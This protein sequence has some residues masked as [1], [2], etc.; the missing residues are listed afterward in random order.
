MKKG[1]KRIVW[2]II[3]L[4]IIALILFLAKGPIGSFLIVQDQLKKVDVIVVLGGDN[5]RVEEA[6]RL[7]KKG[8]LRH[9]IMSGG[10]FDAQVSMA[11]VMKEQA[12]RLDV[13]QENI[14]VEAEA[15]HTFEHPVFVKPIMQARGFKSAIVVSSPY[16]MRRT[17]MLFDRTFKNSGIDLI[18]YPVQ[19]TWF[20]VDR[21]WTSAPSRRVVVMEYTKLV[22]NFFGNRFSKFVA[23][24]VQKN[25]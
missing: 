16:H 1:L 7:Y 20:N 9:I 18:Y 15:R 5:E 25:Q 21:W 19:D 13:P 12:V 17:A 14:I 24:L 8:F 4:F 3:G 2:L 22:I 11:E 23:N 6:A 10:S